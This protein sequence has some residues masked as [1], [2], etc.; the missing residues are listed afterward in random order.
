MYVHVCMCR[1]PDGEF[2]HAGVARL[3]MKFDESNIKR[4]HD[5][6]EARLQ[7]SSSSSRSRRG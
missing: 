1:T 4:I 2:E 5:L 3:I 7:V 6:E